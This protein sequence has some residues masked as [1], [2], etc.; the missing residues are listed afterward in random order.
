MIQPIMQTWA[1]EF[2]HK[3]N[4]NQTFHVIKLIM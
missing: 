3:K 2:R 4:N 1:V